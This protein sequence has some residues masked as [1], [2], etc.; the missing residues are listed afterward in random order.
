M[1]ALLSTHL[2][3]SLSLCQSYLDSYPWN[4]CYCFL[5]LSLSLVLVLVLKHRSDSFTCTH[6]KTR[7]ESCCIFSL[8]KTRR[9]GKEI[10]F[11][12]DSLGPGS[13][14]FPFLF[15]GRMSLFLDVTRQSKPALNETWLQQP[16]VQI[17]VTPCSTLGIMLHFVR[18]F[19]LVYYHI[20]CVVHV[21]VSQVLYE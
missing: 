8:G 10:F 13:S 5:S 16:F 9:R 18:C 20:S 17:L 12:L 11:F 1:V 21:F 19:C 14:P 15:L 3:L 2:S 7:N 4:S 6:T